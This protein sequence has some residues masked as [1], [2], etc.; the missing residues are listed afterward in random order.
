M[1][2][3]QKRGDQLTAK[4]TSVAH[5]AELTALGSDLAAAQAELDDLEARWLE[6][7]EQQ[8]G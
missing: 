8:E 4:L 3:A 6:L 1:V 2:R 5:H 7:A